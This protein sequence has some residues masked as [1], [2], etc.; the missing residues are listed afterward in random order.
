MNETVATSTL[1]RRVGTIGYLC[2]AA[3]VGWVLVG[4]LLGWHHQIRSLDDWRARVL[5]TLLGMTF[6]AV[7]VRYQ[8]RAASAAPRTALLALAANGIA[9]VCFV[10]LVWTGWKT[11]T[12]LWRAWW[13][14]AVVAVAATHVLVLLTRPGARLAGVEGGAAACSAVA[15][16]MLA[17]PAL[18]AD[19]LANPGIVYSVLLALP[20]AGSGVGSFVSWRRGRRVVASK[21]WPRVV[22][23]AT[24]AAA[25][26]GVLL[27]GVYIGR[28]TAPA[29][30][31]FDLMPSVLANLSRDELESQVR[32]DLDR[33]KVIVAGIDELATK[34]AATQAE[35][36][37]KR[38]AENREYFRPDEEDQI[39]AH[40]MSYLA[41][42]A[43]LLR[44]V[45]TY[46][47][48]QSVR[49]PD[50]RARCFLVGYGAGTTVL[51]ASL[52]LVTTYRDEPAVRQKLNE[53]DPA[54]GLPAGM[55]DRIYENVASERNIETFEEMATY[56]DE[57]RSQWR[58]ARVLPEEDFNW[59]DRHISRNIAA[60]RGLEFDR[61]SARLDQIIARVKK[62]TYTPVYATQSVVSTWI[63]DT[64]LVGRPPFISA[65]QIAQIE[66]M[67]QP[68]DI[69]LERRNWFFSNA[70]LPGFWPHGALYAGRIEHLERLG[71][72]RRDG[73]RWTSE[74]PAVRE[75]LADYVKPA[76]D[77]GVHTVIESVSEGVI[78]NSLTESMHADYVAALRP[79]LSDTDKARAIV[80]A[81]EHQ[82]KPYDF[83]F[84][85][86]SA[87]KLV[88]TELVYRSYEGLLHFPLVRLMGRDTLP[89][90]EICRKFV[91]ERA[92]ADRELDFVLFLDAVPAECCARLADEEAF[93]TSADRPRGFNE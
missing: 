77:G 64:R 54:W 48:F 33:L 9:L 91:R 93:C 31:P 16:I 43:A 75:R 92:N 82:G 55:F 78:F 25:Q 39:R 74:H 38:S 23:V 15:A 70:F 81:F 30:S 69:L 89:A 51:G 88:C 49:D 24:F 52:S 58:Q 7:L 62:S 83:E 26:V 32:G 19:I 73:D 4:L 47:G 10:L 45:A 13:L 72:V 42:R 61:R 86:F 14:S 66:A 67:L 1:A 29:T 35:I 37:G 34:V 18:R 17:R 28:V 41:Y 3:A 36:N 85:F 80:R 6:G 79:R 40:F 76:H 71:I 20:I 63:G 27:A 60:V 46:A 44:M 90:L 21:P 84:D 11:Q 50:P 59:L 12:A 53:A 57:K 65:Q 22:K 8:A 56:F 68:G 87:D 2:L 5:L